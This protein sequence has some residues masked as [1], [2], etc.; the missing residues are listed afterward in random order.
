MLKTA[1]GDGE[2]GKPPRPHDTGFGKLLC[3]GEPGPFEPC[4]SVD[5][6]GA[7]V[8]IRGGVYLGSDAARRREVGPCHLLVSPW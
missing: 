5:A 4:A 7:L 6:R 1:D 8:V 2:R 3:Q